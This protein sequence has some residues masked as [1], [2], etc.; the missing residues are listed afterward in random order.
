[1]PFF[2]QCP[3]C[4][5]RFNL[6]YSVVVI[7]CPLCGKTFVVDHLTEGFSWESS[8]PTAATLPVP[9]KVLSPNLAEPKPILEEPSDPPVIEDQVDPQKTLPLDFPEP[10]PVFAEASAPPVIEDQANPVPLDFPEPL[11]IFTEAPAPPV[12]EDQVKP[13]HKT[14]PAQELLETAP[15]EE[16]P[17]EPPPS[18]T[19]RVKPVPKIVPTPVLP[20]PAPSDAEDEEDSTFPDWLSPWS[21]AAFGFGVVALLLASLLGVRI[22]TIG[23]SGGGIV[24]A[25]LGFW[26]NLQKGP[27]RDRVTLALGGTISGGVLILALFVPGVINSRWARDFSVPA[28]DPNK[29]VQVPRDQPRL[30]GKPLSPDDWV[31]AVQDA[32]RQDDVFIRLESVQIDQLADK[33]ENKYLQ[34]HLRLGN[35]GHERTIVVTGF[36]P[37]KDQPV[38]TDE[39][40]KPYPFLEQR[41]RKRPRGGRGPLVFDL[42]GPQ[43]KEVAA[44]GYL[45]VLL[46]FEA[47]AAT[48]AALNLEVP[49]AAWGRTGVCKFRFPESFKVEVKKGKSWQP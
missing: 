14:A 36:S 28:G 35:S 13:A 33:G 3:F 32:I 17:P 1:M 43:E 41:L 22:L 46:V 27:A 21:L 38:L 30:E 4:R 45:D 40:G 42:T 44:T 24:M 20:R 31:D 47:P 25:V 48:V 15:L 37:D 34:V 7:G 6:P 18:S 16:S 11:P 23:L 29:L 39:S 8:T 19:D 49:A 9:Q 26:T 10:L 12:I 2:M 5:E